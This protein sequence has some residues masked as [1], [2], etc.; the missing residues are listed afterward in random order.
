MPRALAITWDLL[1]SDLPSSTKNATIRDFDRV[2]GLDLVNWQPAVEEIPQDILE[3]VHKRQY[4][5]LNK[6][7][8]DADALRD[9]IISAGYEIEDTPTGPRVKQKKNTTYG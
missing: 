9:Q 4:A 1:K 7:W 5:R 3:L 6:R 8:I 2:L